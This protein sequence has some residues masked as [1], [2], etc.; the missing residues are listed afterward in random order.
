MMRYIVLLL[1]V[2]LTSCRASR[3]T[4][5]EERATEHVTVQD[6][7]AHTE[8]G[9]Q[10]LTVKWW[11]E[12]PT[13]P[14]SQLPETHPLLPTE[15]QPLGG[16]GYSIELVSEEQSKSVSR[17]TQAQSSSTSYL[18]R[19]KSE[20]NSTVFYLGLALGLSLSVLHII[21]R[22]RRKSK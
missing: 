22:L 5:T 20:P 8:Q 13:T 7:V 11:G 9:R 2:L 15:P 19:E 1:L 10:R 16:G 18:A 3:Q 6:S 17:D 4:V 14:V 12:P 21:Y